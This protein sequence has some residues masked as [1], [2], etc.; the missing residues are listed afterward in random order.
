ME[1][2]PP[3]RR[4]LP[5]RHG[6]PGGWAGRGGTSAG[7][8]ASL[9]A[10]L[11]ALFAHR[12]VSVFEAWKGVIEEASRLEGRVDILVNNAGVQLRMRIDDLE[13]AQW[14][15]VL[16]TNVNGQLFGIKATASLMKKKRRRLDRQYRFDLRLGR[17]AECRV[18]HQ[19]MGGAR[20]DEMRGLRV[21][22]VEGARQRW[23]IQ[24]NHTI[25][26][27]R[28]ASFSA[29]NTLIASM[30]GGSLTTFLPNTLAKQPSCRCRSPW[31]HRP[32]ADA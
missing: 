2:A 15:R 28:T 32:P 18:R 11:K 9:G 26:R 29:S 10:G 24:P 12:D 20:I 17:I 16:A 25:P 30:K 14:Q 27:C 5:R 31:D 6:A 3:S 7:K 4:R 1:L 13:I 21:R 19:Q 22:Q 23:R 8:A